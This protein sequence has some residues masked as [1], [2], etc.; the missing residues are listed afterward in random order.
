[1]AEAMKYWAFISYSHA[2]EAWARW[3]HTSLETW[4][5][6]ARLVGRPLGSETVPRKLFPIFRDRDELP[7]SHELGAVI[8][9][10]LEGSRNLIVICS[11]RSATSRWVNEEISAFRALGRSERVFCLIVDGEPHAS[12]KPEIAFSECFPPALRTEGFEPIAADARPRKDG[13]DGAKLKLLAGILGIGLDELKQRE[14]QRQRRQQALTAAAAGVAVLALAGL[15]RLYDQREQARALDARI[16]KLYDSGRRE[17]LSHHEGRAAVYL[18]EALAL[19][20]DT[21]ALRFMLGQA[22]QGPDAQEKIVMQAGGAV[23]RPAYSG[24]G[25]RIVT[26]TQTD[27]GTVAQIWD[28]SGGR[29]IA[30]LEGL[31]AS[32]LIAQFIGAQRVLVSGFTE[33]DLATS[34]GTG[35]FTGVW[36]AETGKQLSRIQGHSGRFGQPVDRA[37][38]WLITADAADSPAARIWSLTDGK[39]VHALAP[40]G[41]VLAASLSPDGR[42]AVTGDD[43]GRVY[44]WNLATLRSRLLPGTLPYHVVGALFSADGRRV[45]ATGRKGDVRVW[46]VTSGALELAF[47][48]DPLGLTD[49]QVSAD[50]RT[51]VTAGNAGYK[52]WDL[53]RGILQFA[54]GEGL[55]Q[56]AEVRLSPDASLAIA[57]DNAEGAAVVLDLPSRS[58]MLRL[59]EFG[60]ASAAAF[61][62]DGRQLL[63]ATEHGEI[64][65]W[66]LPVRRLLGVRHEP[67]DG[68]DVTLLAAHFDPGGER[69][70]TGAHD[71]SVRLWSSRTGELLHRFEEGSKVQDAAF[72]PDGARL[73]SLTAEGAL[74]LRDAKTLRTLQILQRGPLWNPFGAL[75]FSADSRYFTALPDAG[76]PAVTA[77]DVWNLGDGSVATKLEFGCPVTAAAFG[78]DGQ[79]LV[80][81]C[82]NGRIQ[83]LAIASGA[84]SLDLQGFTN[85]IR[86]VPLNAQGSVA[87]Y[88]DEDP[89]V[90]V[91]NAQGTELPGLEAPPS[92]VPYSL[93][94]APGGELAA[95]LSGGA[96]LVRAPGTG[97]RTLPGNVPVNALTY[98]PGGLLASYG[99]DSAVRVWDTRRGELLTELN[100]NARMLWTADVRT[101]GSALLSGGWDG[102]AIMSAIAPERR[103]ASILQA[104]LR[105]RVPWIAKG[106]GLE[107]STAACGGSGG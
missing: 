53:S 91:W 10:A 17:L 26:P 73:L 22:M 93:A 65:L 80:A 45:I 67:N 5:V 43:A 42:Y 55:T 77:L 32:P 33:E 48:A 25:R 104:T 68:N 107:N 30:Q 20:R 44:L 3:L 19:G 12:A 37:G 85:R 97:P 11:P 59:D 90:R 94:L 1:M 103:N 98:L 79:S 9:R 105:C 61:S 46:D 41:H 83:R 15:W 27:H 89:R 60:P 24:D 29:R 57:S 7:S 16:E 70:L 101:D 40:G 31:P 74:R 51:L 71:G 52:F 8:N 23:R 87:A 72:S 54:H 95:G 56:W 88:A 38:R 66:R 92:Q 21:P 100:F 39:L 47:A 64:R 18:T 82:S 86:Q 99:T 75:K 69:L 35:A 49:L 96:I 78:T 81:G 63:T 13:K 84:R 14:K 102:R 58:V 4:R 2:D 6:P 36:D 62:A 76:T 50:G 106:D 34:R 28:T